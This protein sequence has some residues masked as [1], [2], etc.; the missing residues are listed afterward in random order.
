[1]IESV[2]L[3][4][5]LLIDGIRL[6]DYFFSLPSSYDKTELELELASYVKLLAFNLLG[7]IAS[8]MI[9]CRSKFAVFLN[10]FLEDVK[11]SESSSEST[12]YFT[13]F[14]KNFFLICLFFIEKRIFFINWS[15]VTFSFFFFISTNSL[16]RS[17]PILIPSAE[18][19]DPDLSVFRM[20]SVQIFGSKPNRSKMF[21]PR[22]ALHWHSLTLIFRRRIEYSRALVIFIPL[23][24]VFTDLFILSSR[25]SNE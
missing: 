15:L 19:S 12:D 17:E 7:L 3:T 11:S 5:V 22:F 20:S 6:M 2:Y 8:L 25:E 10:D 16:M 23:M 24:A 4:L 9:L 14:F 21:W 13:L 18:P 1:M